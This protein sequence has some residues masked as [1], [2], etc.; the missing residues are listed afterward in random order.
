MKNVERYL[1]SFGKQVVLKTQQRLKRLDKVV[2]GNL[3]KSVKFQVV[4][5]SKGYTVEFSMIDYG[6]FVDK[7]VSGSIQKRSY[8]DYKG[9][10]RESPFQ[11]GKTRDGGL[12]RGLDK[13]I[14]K[15]GIAPRDEKGKFM[16]RASLKFLI[17]RKIYLYGR[18]GVGFFQK[19][20]KFGLK[21]FGKELLGSVKEDIIT[22]IT[23]IK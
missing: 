23:K 20:L 22:N 5:T 15:R 3:L 21:K 6:K 14:V 11:Y 2:T 4:K 19:P 18:N 13:W 12:T 9:K 17:A 1:K 8:I 7:G 16:S 10:K